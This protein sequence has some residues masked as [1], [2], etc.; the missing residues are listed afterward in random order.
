MIAPLSLTN[1]ISL[2]SAIICLSMI[3]SQTT[4]RV[5]SV[6][7]LA[8]PPALAV[9]V[10]LI[11]LAGVFDAGFVSDGLWVIGAIVGFIL[12]RVR[13]QMLSMEILPAA[14]SIRAAQ[15]ADNL[16]AALMLLALTSTDF[17]SAAL[18]HPLLQPGLVAIG[19]AVCAGFLAGRFLA[20]A[21]RADPVA[22]LRK[23]LR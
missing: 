9:V 15:T 4:G 18:R 3:A 12:G 23:G 7:R 10:A 21:L 11:L 14:R 5:Q 13:G 17:I 6:S 8:L 19:G 1:V 20:I 22:R 2:L 16:V